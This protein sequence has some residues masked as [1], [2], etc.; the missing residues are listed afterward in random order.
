[1]TAMS[2]AGGTASEYFSRAIKDVERAYPKA[3]DDTKCQ[4][5]A[6][7]AIAASIDYLSAT[8]GGVI[9][10]TAIQGALERAGYN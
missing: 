1:M 7:L 2:Q 3:S 6:T 4:A 8:L 5:A 9:N 10:E